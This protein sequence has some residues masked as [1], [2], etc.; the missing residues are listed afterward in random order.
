MQVQIKGN[1]GNDPELKFSKGNKAYVT[2]SVGYTPRIKQ[3]DQYVNGDTTWFR[4]VQF[5]KKAEAV[6]DVIKKGDAVLVV[7]Q[8]RQSSYKDKDG[9]NKTV[10]EIIADEIGVVPKLQNKSR[11]EEAEPAWFNQQIT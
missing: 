8:M 3:G 9:N 11:V 6:A 5:D 2:F 4:V 1:V 7:G 10:L